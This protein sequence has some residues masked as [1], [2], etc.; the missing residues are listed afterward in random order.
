[1]ME[2]AQTPGRRPMSV[3][4]D[5]SLRPKQGQHPFPRTTGFCFSSRGGLIG[6]VG[7]ACI[8]GHFPFFL[9][10]FNWALSVSYAV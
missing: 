4:G 5:A 3:H 8:V 2:G 6:P 1:M 10:D 7:S 9:N